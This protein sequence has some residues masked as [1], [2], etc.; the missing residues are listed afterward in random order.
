MPTDATR[1]VLGRRTE[2]TC[3][4]P[5]IEALWTAFLP[6][7]DLTRH[8]L[9]EGALGDVHAVIADQGERFGPEHRI[10]RAD[11][12]GE[13]VS[14]LNCSLLG[15]TPCEAVLSGTEGMLTL[16]RKFFAP[17]PFTLSAND[18]S[19]R[20]V[21]QEEASGYAGFRHQIAHVAA[22]IAEGRTE[23]PIR[24]LADTIS[25]LLGMDRTRKR[26]GIVFAE[27]V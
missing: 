16:P 1:E 24:P 27:G 12:A 17:G 14:H 11:L 6:K 20:L 2:Q 8:L 25:T 19:T 23:P 15:L 4:A 7:Y 9:A 13:A 22:C 26:L 10:M 21:H 3:V 5:L 18:L